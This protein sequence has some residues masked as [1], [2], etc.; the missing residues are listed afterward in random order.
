MLD[1]F[2]ENSPKNAI[3][4]REL[5]S[6]F[7]KKWD[8]DL[9]TVQSLDKVSKENG[10]LLVVKG[11]LAVEAHLGGKLSRA[12]NDIDAT[13]YNLSGLTD[14]QIFEFVEKHIMAEKTI[15]ELY[16]KS[17]EKIEFR[18]KEDKR[19][20]FSRRRL[21]LQ[22]ASGLVQEM[23]VKK[24]IFS[25]GQEINVNV[26]ELY[27]LVVHKIH[28]LYMVNTNPSL[29]ER[30]T[31]RSDYTDLRSLIILTKYK[32]NK[33]IQ[34]LSKIIKKASNPVEKATEEYNFVTG[35]LSQL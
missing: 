12:H 24:L 25:N 16:K 2:T 27:N 7:I 31:N 34:N 4:D 29:A 32:K 35:L 9:A 20:F 8:L 17:P 5:T 15:W 26:L 19:P 18:E 30:T 13:F 33:A 11:G 10:C 23:E 3:P 21:E 14:S 28:K 1:Q 22:V 6:E